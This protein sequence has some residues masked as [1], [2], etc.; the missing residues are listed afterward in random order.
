[1]ADTSVRVVLSA[2]ASQ[3]IAEMVK[4]GEATAQVAKASDK[5]GDSKGFPA[6]TNA[7]KAA[8]VVV[9]ASAGMMIKSWMDFDQQ[10]SAVA[11]T[12]DE[13]KGA[14]TELSAA[15]RS[16][17]VTKMG[18]GAKDAA[19][20]ME[21]LLK[22]GVGVS[23]LTSGA[24]TGSLALAAAGE[25]DVG[26]AAEIAST[27]MTQFGKS[28]K[29]V[30]HIAD[31][32]AAGAGK[33]QGGVE[34]LGMGLQQSGLVASQMGIS[35]EETVGTLTAF[36]SA[37]LLGSDAGTSFK[38]M[39]QRLSNPSGEA[40][41][42][43]EKLGIAAYDA[44]GK[45]VGVS[46]LAGQLKDKLSGL[47]QE[48]RDA[49]M[50]T[51]FGSDAVRAASVL[52]QQGAEGISQWTK[53]V[54]S[55]GYA[56]QVAADRQNN[57]RGDLAKLKS[58]ITNAFIAM[59]A[60]ADGPLRKLVQGLGEMAAFAGRHTTL[61]AT[62]MGVA[63]GM[64]AIGGAAVG[65]A[66]TA[67]VIGEVRTAIA[68]LS[69][70]KNA[71][72]AISF[73]ASIFGKSEVATR[74]LGSAL[75]GT[76]LALGAFAAAAA[77]GMLVPD[78]TTTEV[79]TFGRALE[80]VSKGANG[81]VAE[82]NKVAAAGVSNWGYKDKVEDL[83]GLFGTLQ[84]TSGVTK[85]IDKIGL[86]LEKVGIQIDTQY[87][88]A[89]KQ[90]T[91]LDEAL[92][93][94]SIKDGSE[95]FAQ[96]A[97]S[98]SKAGMSADD[99]A[100]SMPKTM[101]AMQAAASE[102]GVFNL[103]NQE[104]VDWMGGK[105]PA[106]VTKA[107]SAAAA[108]GQDVSNLTTVTKSAGQT[109]QEAAAAVDAQ[110][111][112]YQALAN[113]ALAASGS[114]MALAAAIEGGKKA[115]TQVTKDFT[116]AEIASGKAL[117]INTEKGRANRTALDG[118]ASS[119]WQVIE[120]QRQQGASGDQLAK[121][122]QKT[123]DAFVAT[124]VQMGMTKQAANALANQYGLIPKD[125]KT[126]VSTP[127][128]GASTEQVAALRQR[129]AALPA[130]R[131]TEIQ[132]IWD[133][134]GYYAAMTSLNS[135]NG[136]TSHTYVVTEYISRTK[137][138]GP[139]GP[140]V[141]NAN[142]SIMDYY[143]DGG[144]RE[145]HVAQIA[146]AGA[147][148]VWAEPETGG[149][150]YIPFAASKRGRSRQIAE[151]T[152]RRL[153]GGGIEWYASGGLTK[154]Q[155]AATA[156]NGTITKLMAAYQM[157][158]AQ[159]LAAAAALSKLKASAAGVTAT[160]NRAQAVTNRAKRTRDADK[161]RVDRAKDTRDR[162]VK[163]AN[164]KVDAAKT[165]RDKRLA[166]LKAK[167]ASS[168][169]LS[170][171]RDQE[172][173]KVKAAQ[174]AAKRVAD[175]EAVKVKAAQDKAK[176]SSAAYTSALDKSKAA[177]DKAK[178]AQEKASDAA[179]VMAERQ[180]ALADTARQ[181]SESYRS[182]YDQGLDGADWIAQMKRGTSDLASFASQIGKLRKAGLSETLIQEILGRGVQ[183]G[184][185]LADQILKGGSSIVK[186]LNTTSKG[187]QAQ[188]DKLGLAGA[189]GVKQYASGGIEDHRAQ[190]T[191][192]GSPVRI[193]S[194]PETGGES[195]IPLAASKRARSIPIWLE[196]GR[197]LGVA[198]YA[199]GAVLG[200]RP[201]H[202]PTLDP[203]VIATAVAGALVGMAVVLDNQRV[204]QIVDSRIRRSDMAGSFAAKQRLG[205]I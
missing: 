161:T 138:S 125:V 121:V 62:L 4:A 188:A 204:G 98:A 156:S 149:E 78:A 86:G 46:S 202:M 41:R 97:A 181:A 89:T 130:S 51:I 75:S 134:Q 53:E 117:D 6:L 102:V 87:G 106:A 113:Q 39:L 28:G 147:W 88:T 63:T 65:I 37:G 13:A 129:I 173:A 95:A 10:M 191:A 90:V 172:A 56:A 64:L 59:G 148:R 3:Y 152:V 200:G 94:M 31:L 103:S 5:A 158:T 179:K 1:M 8:G 137:S 42:E 21:E 150:A 196:T 47:S 157:P 123:R 16:S 151:E 168:K 135:I 69:I 166:K 50:A 190:I 154:G 133:S 132:S 54:D 142:G 60:A 160:A 186:A 38:S 67:A 76:A 169:T 115:A 141:A 25:M 80:G 136:K 32:L 100:K 36:A 199:S 26:K 189:I 164:R 58:E 73:M 92:S 15:A 144:V 184:S 180:K 18:Y 120:A 128:V 34:D 83:D 20:G 205:G 124:A 145:H 14:L 85:S 195:Y 45:F 155:I 2:N 71:G 77:V 110:V 118:I 143:A 167:G 99:L 114:E 171:V 44:E 194:E 193:W 70:A 153:G 43:L 55:S 96:I 109:A 74:N 17:E 176:K 127:G 35:L 203:N 185:Y 139:G 72:T 105:V 163:A 197:R 198:G 7:A 146:P 112:A 177:Q 165:A 162:N 23:D 122:T 93:Q 101:S 68:G 183:D 201:Q 66:K 33:A 131:A 126:I 159:I 11:A 84:N 48:Q 49:A 82:L 81:A 192:A 19:R 40:A 91:N 30:G 182:L 24:M 140:N 79:E 119:G 27:A 104:L 108:A 187:L 111:K 170:K 57:L 29:D 107:A 22:A 52:Y 116:A 174:A 12:G 178:A 61:T 175:R 9:G